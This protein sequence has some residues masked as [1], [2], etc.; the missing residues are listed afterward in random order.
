MRIDQRQSRRVHFPA[1]PTEDSLIDG[2][3][4]IDRDTY[5]WVLRG[6]TW[7]THIFIYGNILHFK[8]KDR[9]T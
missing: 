8:H 5:R 7:S 1:R 3:P 9:T 4:L 6:L 2:G